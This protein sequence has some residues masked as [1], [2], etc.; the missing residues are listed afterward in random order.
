MEC[1]LYAEYAVVY[2]V[3]CS[4]PV[5]KDLGKI[6][7]KGADKAI[8]FTMRLPENVHKSGKRWFDTV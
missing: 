4:D 3:P 7:S 1:V 6:E 2:G 8:S 5:Y